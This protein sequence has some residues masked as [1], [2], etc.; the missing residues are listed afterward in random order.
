[1]DDMARQA[2]LERLGWKFVRIRGSEF[3]RN[4][5]SAMQPIFDK[6]S[7]LDI[8][9][10]LSSGDDT[11]T[12]SVDDEL[13]QRVIRRAEEIRQSWIENDVSSDFQESS[14]VTSDQRRPVSV[15]SDKSMRPAN[16][17]PDRH[18]PDSTGDLFKELTTEN[19]K[20]FELTPADS[21]RPIEQVSLKEIRRALESLLSNDTAMER[22]AL[23][24]MLSQ[25][26]GYRRMGRKIRSRLNKTIYREVREGRLKFDADGK[27]MRVKQS[28][29]LPQH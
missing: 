25:N 11:T 22:T 13:K 12:D 7:S 18:R 23:L 10:E 19:Q 3:F 24:T 16:S 8:P 29:D 28:G 20:H 27:V 1:M 6:L 4:P 2:I 26:L 17:Q 15:T 21:Q 9:P 5:H 14:S